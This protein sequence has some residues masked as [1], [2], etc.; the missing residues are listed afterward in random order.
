[1]WRILIVDDDRKYRRPLREHFE[2]VR[3]EVCE[4]AEGESVR[5]V[6]YRLDASAAKPMMG[7]S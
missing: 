5:G 2:R 7:A 4:S 1:M 6:G 3:H